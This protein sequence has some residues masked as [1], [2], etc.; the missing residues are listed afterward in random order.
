[1]REEA[2]QYISVLNAARERVASQTKYK[3]WENIRQE[4][5]GTED[6]EN[7]LDRVGAV[8]Y[9]IMNG[10]LIDVTLERDELDE[11]YKIAVRD[12]NTAREMYKETVQERDGWI[13][14]AST[15]MGHIQELQVERDA[16]AAEIRG[17]EKARDYW[18]QENKIANESIGILRNSRERLLRLLN[19]NNIEIPQ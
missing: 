7:Y 2:E 10:K 17:Y 19:K 18:I 4:L 5:K 12:R 9:D 6:Y 8:V 14:E 11:Q 15:L 13:N 16:L 1:M 3:R